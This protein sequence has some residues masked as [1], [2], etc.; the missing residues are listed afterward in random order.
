MIE[1]KNDKHP[2]IPRGYA[3]DDTKARIDWVKK[4]SGVDLDDNTED[5]PEELK[6]IIENHVGF[7]KVPM[8]VVGPVAISGTYANGDFCVPLCTLEG[9][10]AMSMNRGMYASTLS[11]GTKVRHFRQELSR[12]PVFIFENLDDSAKFQSWV[13]NNEARIIQAAESS[14]NH[15]KVLR[16]DQ[17]TVQNYVFLILSWI[18]ETLLG[19][20]WLPSPLK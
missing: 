1:N 20:T 17:Y 10:L 2:S 12:A 3:A 4:F 11:G 15:G 19:K 7:M 16:I 9:T 8:A 5:T 13:S 6:G 18:R 14:T